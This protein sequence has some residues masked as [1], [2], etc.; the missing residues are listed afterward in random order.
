MFIYLLLIFV[1]GGG[2]G[3]FNGHRKDSR[4]PLWL[5]DYLLGGDFSIASILKIKKAIASGGDLEM[6][7]H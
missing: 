1:G 7:Q 4:K 6:I 2:G 3:W 5:A